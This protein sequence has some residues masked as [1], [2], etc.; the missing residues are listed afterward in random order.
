MVHEPRDERGGLVVKQLGER[1]ADKVVIITG[2]SSGLG[3]EM[4]RNFAEE[5]AKV[6]TNSRSEQRAAAAAEE[7]RAEGGDAAPVSAD[8]RTWEGA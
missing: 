8:V 6:V 7:I 3:L 1:F 2:S 4:A 5:G